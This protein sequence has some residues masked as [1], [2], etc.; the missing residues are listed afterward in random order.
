MNRAGS[1]QC[2]VVMPF[3]KKMLND[4]SGREYD[5]DKV[6]R[7]IMQRAIRLAGLLPVRADERKGANLIHTDMFTDLR[8]HAVVLVDLSLENPNVFYELGIRHVMSPRGTVLMSR[9]GAE[10]PFDVKLSRVIFYKYD[11]V[12]LDWEVAERIVQELQVA[13]EEAKRGTPDSPVHTLLERV[14]RDPEPDAVSFGLSSFRSSDQRQALDEFQQLVAEHWNSS[15]NSLRELHS[16][17]G[18]SPFGAR[19]LGYFVLGRETEPAEAI[20]VGAA[21]IMPSNTIWQIGSSSNS[22]LPL[23]STPKTSCD[24]PH[25]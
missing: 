17:H 19:A 25:P 1:D 24:S 8:D 4:G 15:G 18:S 23:S 22:L 9:E 16:Q 5:F 20:L 6:Y 7:V 13:L 21:F 2:F 12:S 3:G 10:L 14:L 11:G